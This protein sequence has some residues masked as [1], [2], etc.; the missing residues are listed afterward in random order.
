M[1]YLLNKKII[2]IKTFKKKKT[3]NCYEEIDFNVGTI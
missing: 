1:T 2:L 3:K